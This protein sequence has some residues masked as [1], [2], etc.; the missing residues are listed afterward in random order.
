[1]CVHAWCFNQRQK[2]RKIIEGSGILWHTCCKTVVFRQENRR[3]IRVDGHWRGWTI[4]LSSE[5]LLAAVGQLVKFSSSWIGFPFLCFWLAAENVLLLVVL[6]CAL[7]FASLDHHLHL[8][9]HCPASSFFK[10]YICGRDL[11]TCVLPYGLV[12]GLN[13]QI[14]I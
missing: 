8:S 2:L 14:R 6:F 11:D 1:M 7:S 5:A 13:F 12:S 3:N 10:T 4:K 9:I